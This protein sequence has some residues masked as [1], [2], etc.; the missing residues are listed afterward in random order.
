MNNHTPAPGASNTAK[1]PELGSHHGECFPLLSQET[2]LSLAFKGI[3]SCVITPSTYSF[4]PSLCIYQ[5]HL[6]KICMYLYSLYEYMW[7]KQ[8]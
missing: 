5:F 2:F 6:D 3:T 8:Q 1:G 7:C 4:S